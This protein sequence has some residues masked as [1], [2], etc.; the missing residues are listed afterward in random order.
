MSLTD[1]INSEIK[2]AMLARNKDRLEALRAVK[3]AFVLAKTQKRVGDELSEDEELKIVQ[4]LAKQRKDSAD[5]YREQKRDDLFDKEMLEYAVIKEF[6]PAQM[7]EAAI[8]LYLKELIA[9]IGA[10]SMQQMGQVMGR[11]TKELAGKAEGK[12][13]SVVVKELLS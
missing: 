11:A 5:I 8:R 3:T 1:T 2:A 12:M 4:K 10:T 13:I 9:E 7:D 6:I